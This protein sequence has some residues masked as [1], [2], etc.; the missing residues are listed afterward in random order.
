MV[1]L[2]PCISVE[3]AAYS[4]GQRRIVDVSL[5]LC[6]FQRGVVD[7]E[8]VFIMVIFFVELAASWLGEF[9]EKKRV[10]VTWSATS[11]TQLFLSL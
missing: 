10:I 2:L 6:Y 11:L 7:S 1:L 3:R 8:D 4:A 5:F 9:F